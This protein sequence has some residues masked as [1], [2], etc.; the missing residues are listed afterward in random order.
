MNPGYGVALAC[1]HVL[2]WALVFAALIMCAKY[3]SAPVFLTIEQH[4]TDFLEAATI[5]WLCFSVPC[6]L[7]V[8]G[9]NPEVRSKIW[10]FGEPKPK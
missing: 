5:A 8:L 2:G 10:H 4:L 7:V 3:M 6:L 1:A 9:L